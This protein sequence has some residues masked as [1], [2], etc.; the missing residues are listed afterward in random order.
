VT[1]NQG[2]YNQ[3]P[4]V[5]P[6]TTGLKRVTINILMIFCY[7]HRS[8]LVQLASE[9]YL[10]QQMGHYTE[11]ALNGMCPSNSSP[12]SSVN[13]EEEESIRATEDGGHQENKAFEVN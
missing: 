5:K 12:Q 7:T 3:C 8:V 4:R 11:L 10:L 9:M 1:K 6:K 2:L 13:S